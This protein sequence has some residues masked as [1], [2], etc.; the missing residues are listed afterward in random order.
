MTRSPRAAR[1]CLKSPP[2]CN[3]M[4]IGDKVRVVGIPQ[5][6]P[7]DPVMNTR[8]VFEKCL[9][10]TFL[11]ESF[12]GKRVELMVGKVTGNSLESIFIEPEFLELL[13]K[14]S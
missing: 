1:F 11:I 12:A 3:T 2:F 7:D 14:G 10:R 13:S 9:G 6:L 8:A 4:K 5:D